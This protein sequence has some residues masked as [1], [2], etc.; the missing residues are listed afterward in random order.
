MGDFNHPDICWRDSI[1]R[2]KQHRRFLKCIDDCFLLQVIKEPTRRGAVLDHL[3][4]NK[5]G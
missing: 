3:L 2:H 4:N 5:E 1:A